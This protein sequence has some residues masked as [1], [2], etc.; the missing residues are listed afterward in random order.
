M[1][2]F[3]DTSALVKFFHEEEG[4]A[5]VTELIANPENKTYVSDLARIEFISALHRRYRRK[6]IGDEALEEALQAFD[7]EYSSFY[8]EPMSHMIVQEAEE[9]QLHYGKN[10]GLRTLDAIQLAT[11]LLLRDK[12]WLFVSS[13][14]PLLLAAEAAGA[15]T[16]NPLT[17]KD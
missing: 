1:N 10:H 6:E 5:S 4:T 7:E 13:D 17:P 9:L 3:F 11:F 2:I 15:P 8:V 14:D 16:Y 12:D